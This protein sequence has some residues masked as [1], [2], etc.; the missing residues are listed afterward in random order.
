MR[1]KM[2]PNRKVKNAMILQSY[3]NLPNVSSSLKRIKE[4]K[5]Y[6]K[7]DIYDSMINLKLEVNQLNDENLKQK[8]KI[9]TLMDQIKYKDKFIGD[10]LKSTYQL[11][12]AFENRSPI[13]T[14]TENHPSIF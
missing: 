14:T 8:T 1:R 9:A 10:L 2:S 12:L 7:E 11:S 6:K 3:K 13:I 5:F 4:N